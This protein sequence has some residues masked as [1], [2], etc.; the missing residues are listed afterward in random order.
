MIKS[1]RALVCVATIVLTAGC[2]PFRGEVTLS[3]GS[4][5]ELESKAEP[6]QGDEGIAFLGRTSR[7]H[8]GIAACVRKAVAATTPPLR[9]VPAE[10]LG[11]SGGDALPLMKDALTDDAIEAGLRSTKASVAIADLK[12]RYVFV[13]DG[14][15]VERNWHDSATYG[16]GYGSGDKSTDLQVAVWDAAK[17]ERLGSLSTHSAGRPSLLMIGFI[18][19]LEY[20]PTESEACKHMAGEIRR[21]MAG[22]PSGS[23]SANQ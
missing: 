22:E 20:S 3:P 2:I 18:G 16:V 13:V 19:F 12:L 8:K 15:T 6:L 11:T 14:A 23:P 5:S 7:T 21:Y 1:I 17:G 10:K 9:I 4:I